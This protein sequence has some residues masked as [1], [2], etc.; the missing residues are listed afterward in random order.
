MSK[1]I[2]LNSAAFDTVSLLNA[3]ADLQKAYDKLLSAE[4][5]CLYVTAYGY[6]GP[7]VFS[8]FSKYSAEWLGYVHQLK[9]FCN[10]CSALAGYLKTSPA[11]I[12]EADEL[13]KRKLF[14]I[15]DNWW[16]QK[17]DS[18]SDFFTRTKLKEEVTTFLSDEERE[19]IVNSSVDWSRVRVSE[20]ELSAIKENAENEDELRQKA[21]SL[22]EEKVRERFIGQQT[23]GSQYWDYYSKKD[24]Y[25][26]SDDYWGEYSSYAGEG[27][28]VSAISMSL[29]SL[30]KDVLPKEI[31]SHNSPY[32]PMLISS[33]PEEGLNV[34]CKLMYP[35]IDDAIVNYKTD[36]DKYAPP[37]VA[38]NGFGHYVVLVGKNEDG[39]YIARDPAQGD[40]VFWNGTIDEVYQYWIE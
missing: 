27:C 32:N 20:A 2:F 37:I 1:D 16:G 31:A 7:Y 34:G 17:C 35:S 36:P 30:G 40:S 4:M 13:Y 29:G 12:D 38:T 9:S 19:I 11:E 26:W 39:T 10:R 24:N 18:V 33:I 21:Q 14:K 28:F 23:P 3:Q 25:Y 6:N 22:Y 5:D 15:N 8:V